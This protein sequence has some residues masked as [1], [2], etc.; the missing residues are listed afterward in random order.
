M[1]IKHQIAKQTINE[2]IMKN[3]AFS[4]TEITQ[5]IIGKGGILR[6]SV[7]TTVGEYLERLEEIG[8]IRFSPRRDMFKITFRR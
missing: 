8:V 6:T 5:S 4:Y 3:Q 7:G 1:C 2:R